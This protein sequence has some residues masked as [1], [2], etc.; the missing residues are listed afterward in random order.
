MKDTEKMDWKRKKD[1]KEGEVKQVLLG[2]R[3]C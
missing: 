1:G 3:K 2:N